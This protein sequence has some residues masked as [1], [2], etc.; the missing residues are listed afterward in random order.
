[1]PALDNAWITAGAT[2]ATGRIERDIEALV[3]VSSPSGDLA[4]AEE[5]IAV[6]R[7]LLP[8]EA[9][10]ERLPC[11]SPGHA[12]DLCA[13]LTG[14]GAGRVLLL[15]HLDT[16]HSHADHRPPSRE[17]DRLVG[18]GSI[19]MKGG[20]ALAI[21]AMRALAGAREAFAEVALLLVVDEEWRTGGFAHGPDFAGWDAC[22]CFEAGEEGPE[23]EAAVVLRRK[24]AGTLRV[25]ARGRAAHSGA[26]PDLGR[27]ALLPLA[28]AAERIAA[29]HDP[30][31]PDRL[32]A[33]P[34]VL[35]C[36]DAFN[37]V[38]ATGELVCDLR[39]DSLGAFEPVL[40]AVPPGEE[41]V[42][43]TAEIVRRWPGM[44]TRDLAPP[45]LERAGALAGRPILGS[46]RGGASDA[47][48]MAQHI[49]L[50][51]DGLGPIGAAAHA[52]DEHLLA[53]SLGPRME[54]A[55]AMIAAALQGA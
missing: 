50:T 28:A 10:T 27:S 40:A 52:P 4:G 5:A 25:R 51:V 13:R 17:G 42:E 20:V 8:A 31:G 2:A 16:V 11:S 14:E 48:H 24:A 26:S 46:E 53:S 6:T 55:L 44:D 39:A 1:M 43:V 7:A 37:V 36:G 45:L 35:H 3:A 18:S 12:D 41:G 34:T 29:L 23:G 49:P 21:A 15:G 22:L 33:V 38:P 47:S 19:D 32:S 54:V 30:A 9:A